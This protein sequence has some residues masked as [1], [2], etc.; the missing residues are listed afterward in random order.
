MTLFEY[1]RPHVE[2][3]GKSR[4]IPIHSAYSD[5]FAAKPHIVS[6]GEVIDYSCYRNE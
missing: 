2:F 3:K 4:P 6:K 1:L 5:H